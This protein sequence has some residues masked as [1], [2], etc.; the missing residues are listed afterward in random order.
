MADDVV[1]TPEP[2]HLFDARGNRPRKLAGAHDL[3]TR[4][5]VETFVQ[6]YTENVIIPKMIEVCQHY[7]HQVPGLVARM[8][9]DGFTANGLIFA[10]PAGHTAGGSCDAEAS[11][12]HADS[13]EPADE[14]RAA[15]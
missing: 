12:Q 11:A 1:G 5:E 15:S 3:L 4:K 13:S 7:M 2:S 14:G 10:G 6:N 9:A 8:M